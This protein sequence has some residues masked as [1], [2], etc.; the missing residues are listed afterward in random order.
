M[1]SISLTL[2]LINTTYL[3]IIFDASKH[4]HTTTFTETDTLDNISNKKERRKERS[5]E[6]RTKQTSQHK[7]KSIETLSY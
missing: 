5:Q 4:C 3:P 2:S 6:M 1:D 7:G